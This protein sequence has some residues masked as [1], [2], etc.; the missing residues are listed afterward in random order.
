MQLYLGAMPSSLPK[1]FA[2][3]AA[4]PKPVI[5]PVMVKKPCWINELKRQIDEKAMKAAQSKAKA[6]PRPSKSKRL[7][8][9]SDIMEE[10]L[11][12]D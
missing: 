11:C 1:V 6:R 5:K 10:V 4:K 12:E 3:S 2:P 8:L 9:E 7:E